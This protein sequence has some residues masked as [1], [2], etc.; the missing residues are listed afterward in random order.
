MHQ[1]IV[2]PSVHDAPPPPGF[3]EIE[4]REVEAPG[5]LRVRS[6]STEQK[7]APPREETK[8][9][10]EVHDDHGPLG[11]RPRAGGAAGCVSMI[12]FVAKAPFAFVCYYGGLPA[13][14]RRG[15]WEALALAAAALIAAFSYLMVQCL[16]LTSCLV[17]VC[18][19]IKLQ[20][21]HAIGT[22]LSLSDHCVSLTG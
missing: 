16:E 1:G 8:A 21:P 19:E 6:P 10:E 18:V 5:D 20:A 7:E 13:L 14:R 22:M 17:G 4:L 15:L 3:R 9:P 2:R 12:W 11:R